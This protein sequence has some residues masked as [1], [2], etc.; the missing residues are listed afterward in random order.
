MSHFK[1][2]I[3]CEDKLFSPPTRN[4][5]MP[6]KTV[7]NFFLPFTGTHSL[8]IRTQTAKL[9]SSAFPH[10]T[11]RFIFQSGRRLSGFFSFKD[12][13][14]KLMRSRI[15]KYSCKCCRA[16]YFS[17]TRRHFHTRISERMGV[18]PLMG[19]KLATNSLSSV[20]AHSRQSLHHIWLMI[21]LFLSK[22]SHSYPFLYF[23]FT[24]PSFHCVFHFILFYPYFLVTLHLVTSILFVSSRVAYHHV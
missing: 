20:L 11:V 10:F 8:Q 19:K 1:L 24:R 18:L 14:I 21:S 15:H 7:L 5:N 17:Q 13:I 16:L 9:C 2:R 4:S 3:K 22:T 23:S 12:R 6:D